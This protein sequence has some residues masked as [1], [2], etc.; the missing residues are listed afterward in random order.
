MDL[1]GSSAEK[2]SS[3]RIRFLSPEGREDG[4]EAQISHENS[5]T[6][7]E[8]VTFGGI[9]TRISEK[10]TSRGGKM[11]F[12]TLEDGTASADA[13]VFPSLYGE[14]RG[15]IYVNLPVLVHGSVSVSEFGDRQE[16]N[17]IA[18]ALRPLRTDEAVKAY[19]QIGGGFGAGA[20]GRSSEQNNSGQPD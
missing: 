5:S 19:P 4:A 10:D 8:Y 11:A 13:V 7:K 12:I 16:L 9:V 6:K 15:H 3:L 17:I 1:D 18:D 20:S 14:I 2:L